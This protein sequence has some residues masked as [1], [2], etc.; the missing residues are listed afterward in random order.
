MLGRCFCLFRMSIGINISYIFYLYNMIK[1]GS[2][3]SNFI[4]SNF[5][6]FKPNKNDYYEKFRASF[7]HIF[8][9]IKLSLFNF[10]YHL[11]NIL[12][13]KTEHVTMIDVATI[14]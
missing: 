9:S 3:Y 12:Q 11:I 7:E 4:C 14:R 1:H 2:L 6:P 13:T 10:N 5:S 8:I